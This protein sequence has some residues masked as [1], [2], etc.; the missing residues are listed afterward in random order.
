MRFATATSVLFQHLLQ[1]AIPLVAE[2]GYEGIDIWGGRPHIYRQDFNPSELSGLKAL[3]QAH[4]LQISSFMPAFYRYPHSLSTPNAT[5]RR[6]SIQYMCTCIENAA[7]LGAPIV[8]VVPDNS[9]HGQTRADSLQ[10][11]IESLDEVAR[12]ARNFDLKL[13]VE[14]LY[15]DETDFVNSAEDALHIIDQ[16][17]QSNLG[18]VLDSGTL[19]LSHEPI[20]DLWDK[21]G[22]RF[23]QI[24]VSDNHGKKHQQNLIPGEGTFDFQSLLG[25][26]KR[27]GYNGFVSAELSKEYSSDPAPALRLTLDRLQQWYAQA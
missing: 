11:F 26:L 2:L 14:I 7:M 20:E 24:H 12:F 23:L 10:R 8:L 22:A 21:L 6:D 16:V 3:V 5:A 18:V 1:D 17:G 4:G 25:F 27:K 13:G 9:L 19:N 15:F